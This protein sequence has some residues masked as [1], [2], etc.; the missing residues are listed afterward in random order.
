MSDRI[1]PLGSVVNLKNGDGTKLI[2]V[3]RA[4]IVN[5]HFGE[6]YYDYGGVLIPKGFS[7]PEEVYFFN[8][9]NVNEVLF[10]GYRNNDE[11][12]FEND[13]NTWVKSSDVTKG[14]V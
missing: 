2:I 6:V 8:K 14:S 4:S 11:I 3:S 13:Y 10:E 1:L 7:S 5:E 9:E 12:M